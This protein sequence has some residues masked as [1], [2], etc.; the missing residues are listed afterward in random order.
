LPSKD[1][2]LEASTVSK[3]AVSRSPNSLLL[4]ISLP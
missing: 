2:L 4:P 3:P 1:D